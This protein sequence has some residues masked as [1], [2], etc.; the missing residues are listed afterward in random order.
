VFDSG[1]KGTEGAPGLDELHVPHG[2]APAE[3]GPKLV[4]RDTER[5]VTHVH[6]GRNPA[7]WRKRI[8]GFKM[9]PEIFCFNPLIEIVK[10]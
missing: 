2:A 7:Q 8:F 5:D 3:G 9:P 1:E 10:F 4:L 6:K